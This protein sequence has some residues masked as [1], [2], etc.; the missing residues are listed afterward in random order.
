MYSGFW[1][2]P[3]PEEYWAYWSRHIWLNRYAEDGGAVY[4]D[5]LELLRGQGL[6]CP[7]HQRGPLLPARGLRQ[8]RLFYTQ[9]GLRPSFSAPLPCR[10][11]TYDNRKAVRRMVAEQ[12]NLR[13]PRR[14]SPAAPPRQIHDRESALRQRTKSSRTRLVRRPAPVL[15]TLHSTMPAASSTSSWAW[16]TTPLLSSSTP[17]G[18]GPSPTRTP[19]YACVNLGQAPA[20]AE[21][22][23]P[24]PS[25]STAI[26]PGFERP[27]SF[28]L[29]WSSLRC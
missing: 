6:L 21:S 26:R 5:L 27:E 3:T 16:G 17:S 10:Q 13:V 28:F 7:H 1:P 2:Y 4:G 24:R 19:I 15:R 12:E 18:A 9:G 14:W 11:T 23:L 20:P 25:A 29:T 8:V 22:W